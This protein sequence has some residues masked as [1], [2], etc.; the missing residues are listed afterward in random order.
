MKYKELLAGTV[1]GVLIFLIILEI[2][3]WPVLL[4]S[5]LGYFLYTSGFQM[6]G[7]NKGKVGNVV[8]QLSK[9]GFQD[10]GGQNVA[11]RELTE[12]LEFL[13]DY[14]KAKELGIRPLKGVLLSGPPG[15]GKTL[16]AEASANYTDSVFISTSGS[17]F[18]EIY[19]GVGA[20]RIRNLFSKAKVLAKESKKSSAVIFIDEIEVL[21]GKRG[22]HTSHLEYDQTL[23]Q[24]L[25]EMD[26]LQYESDVKI[27]VIGA[28]NRMD[29][30][31]AAI[32]R[33]GRFDRTV[34]VN[35][36][37]RAG[38]LEILKI[39]LCNKPVM[40][41]VDLEGLARETFGLSGAH[42]ESLCNEAAINALRRGDKQINSDDFAEALNKVILG[43]KLERRPSDEEMK[44][45]CCHEAGHALVAETVRPGSVAQV[46]V[47]PRGNVLGFVRHSAFEDRYLYSKE[48]L[49]EEIQILLAG[50]IAEEIIFGSRSTGAGNDFKRALEISKNIVL[51]GMSSIGVVDRETAPP[52]VIANATND[53]IKRAETVTLNILRGNRAV[54]IRLSEK[55]FQNETVSA[56][57]LKKY[58]QMP[59]KVS[60]KW[61]KPPIG[62]SKRNGRY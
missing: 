61:R 10:V 49:E 13:R 55:L 6:R 52:D 30:L 58:F 22:S 31:D 1:L 33:P 51:H 7:I 14:K 38:R 23:N 26:G 28:T 57:E 48:L 12:A 21:A 47:S 17:E 16:L 32:M 18:I 56:K 59:G 27:L 40:A 35:L 5:A 34:T 44:R 60:W 15:T 2:N 11:K 39:H 46:T 24:L 37:D 19:A 42:L 8:G 45:I 41:E 25:V 50:A 29:L 3:I 36:P 62:K 20:Q 4:V 54:L 53:I 9:V 43:E